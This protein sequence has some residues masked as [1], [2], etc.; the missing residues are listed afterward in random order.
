MRVK[1]I[2]GELHQGRHIE[3]IWTN[4][5]THFK[6]RILSI[7]SRCA[8]RCIGK[9]FREIFTILTDEIESALKELSAYSRSMFAA[10][11]DE[12]LQAQGVN[13]E[14]LNGDTENEDAP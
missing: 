8:R 9:K 1:E 2:R 5:L 12:Y 10:Q 13:L 3:F 4:M 14:S 7:P 11:R 6:Q